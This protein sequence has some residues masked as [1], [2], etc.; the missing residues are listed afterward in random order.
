M[1]RTRL[2]PR[3]GTFNVQSCTGSDLLVDVQRTARALV[4]MR[5]DVVALQEIDRTLQQDQLEEVARAAGFD[6]FEFCGTRPSS[7]GDGE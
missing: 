7:V 6:H 4:A 3:V 1:S 2:G 5:L